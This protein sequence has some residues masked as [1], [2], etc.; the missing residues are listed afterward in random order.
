MKRG[1]ILYCH[2]VVY[3][4]AASPI[5]IIRGERLGEFPLGCIEPGPV[6]W[7]L[8]I[9]IFFRFILAFF[10][11]KSL[12]RMRM[13]P[14]GDMRDR[15]NFRDDGECGIKSR[16]SFFARCSL[17]VVVLVPFE[18]LIVVKKENTKI[19]RVM[20]LIIRCDRTYSGMN[21]TKSF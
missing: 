16:L 4:M 21:G 12:L 13:V 8:T 15:L 17:A 14:N 1:V 2:R 9:C 5:F 7:R 3:F 6:T 19:I 18:L 10:F 11:S 20:A